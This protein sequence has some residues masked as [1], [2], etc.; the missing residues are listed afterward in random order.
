MLNVLFT[1][2]DN[3]LV[4]ENKKTFILLYVNCFLLP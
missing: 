3:H 4:V 1:L 2:H